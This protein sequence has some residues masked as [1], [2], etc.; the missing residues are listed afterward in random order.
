MFSFLSNILHHE[1]P[2]EREVP[3]MKISH[4]CTVDLLSE[5]MLRHPSHDMLH[6]HDLDDDSRERLDFDQDDDLLLDVELDDSDLILD[7]YDL[8]H[9]PTA[10]AAGGNDHDLL[11]SPR[12]DMSMVRAHSIDRAGFTDPHASIAHWLDSLNTG[13]SSLFLPAFEVCHCEVYIL[14]VINVNIP[15]SLLFYQVV[16]NTVADMKKL[17]EK[18]LEELGDRLIQCGARAIQQRYTL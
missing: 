18:Q 11:F 4:R 6:D 3:K 16:G 8:P 1:K 12:S 15:F 9:T 13:P 2:E 17:N 10:P 5:E 14:G 7:Q